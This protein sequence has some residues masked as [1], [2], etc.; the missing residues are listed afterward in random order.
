MLAAN[1]ELLAGRLKETLPC[2]LQ[3]VEIVL[4]IPDEIVAQMD[5]DAPDMARTVLESFALEGYRS[6][7]LSEGDV[8]ELLGFE[9]RMEVHAFLKEHGVYLQYSVADLERD[10]ASALRLRA[11]RKSAIHVKDRKAG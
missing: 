11:A 10:R 1:L 8:R 3:V 9:T 6:E 7:R 5:S 2:Y 4:N